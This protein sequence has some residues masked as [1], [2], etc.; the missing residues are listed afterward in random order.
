MIKNNVLSPPL[1][2]LFHVFRRSTIISPYGISSSK[3]RPEE[4]VNLNEKRVWEEVHNGQKKPMKDIQVSRNNPGKAVKLS[5]KNPGEVAGLN[6]N[7][8]GEDD[9]AS[10]EITGN[11][12]K[13]E[14]S[15]FPLT[16]DPGLQQLMKLLT[17]E[18]VVE[19]V[20]R[21]QAE[22]MVR[23]K[24]AGMGEEDKDYWRNINRKEREK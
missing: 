20:E 18:L 6:Q 24:W 3:R 9:H 12:I 23:E 19:G 7:K 5:Q 1:L 10:Q 17:V 14:N 21:S 8:P 4:E 13:Q 11:A 22:V 2:G 15:S 16:P